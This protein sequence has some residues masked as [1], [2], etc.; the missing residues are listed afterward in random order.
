MQATCKS[1][2]LPKCFNYQKKYSNGFQSSF[3]QLLVESF[4]ASSWFDWMLDAKQNELF[5]RWMMLCFC[6]VLYEEKPRLIVRCK[7]FMIISRL[8][9]TS[10]W[11]TN[12]LLWLSWNKKGERRQKLLRKLIGVKYRGKCLELTKITL[13]YSLWRWDGHGHKYQ[14]VSK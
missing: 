1:V 11:E 2:C 9:N 7:C 13:I 10:D 8:T 5:Q 12:C 6:C 14:G 3:H 4:R